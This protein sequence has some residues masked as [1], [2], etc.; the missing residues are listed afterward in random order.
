MPTPSQA[1]I[2]MMKAII[3]IAGPV[4]PCTIASS[5]AEAGMPEGTAVDLTAVRAL[6]PMNRRRAFR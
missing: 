3:D 1:D 4:G 6:P 2:Q 5:S